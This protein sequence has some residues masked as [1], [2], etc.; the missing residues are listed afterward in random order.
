MKATGD[1]L[2]VQYLEAQDMIDAMTPVGP[3][4]QDDPDA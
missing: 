4:P 2:Q 3:V 1:V